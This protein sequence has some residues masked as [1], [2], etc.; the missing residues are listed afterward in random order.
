M[1]HGHILQ[2]KKCG[3]KLKLFLGVGFVFPK[4]YQETI[5]GAKEGKYGETVQTF[6]EKHPDGA[7]NCDNVLLQCTECG[8]LETEKDLSMYVPKQGAEP[9]EKER[10]SIAFPFEGA[11]YVAPWDLDPDHYELVCRYEHK[12]KKCG[13]KMRTFSEKEM[14]KKLGKIFLEEKQ[15][16]FACPECREPLWQVG[17]MMWD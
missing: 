15:T 11:D 8:N 4:V 5:E 12:C 9:I 16:E 6:L 7:L 13:A 3:Y 17:D 1:G 14:D 2:C 10:W